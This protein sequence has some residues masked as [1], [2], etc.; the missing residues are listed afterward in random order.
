MR[1]GESSLQQC[2]TMMRDMAESK[3]LT[4]HIIR[5]EH[6][7]F[8]L[9]VLAFSKN[10][11]PRLPPPS[12]GE[13]SFQPPVNVKNALNQFS[14]GFKKKTS[15]RS[16]EW[17]Y[18]LGIVDLSVCHNGKEINVSVHPISASLL[19]YLQEK[20]KTFHKSTLIFF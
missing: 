15:N 16:L 1:F 2:D 9:D 20:R 18:Q 14:E 19:L 5:D 3:R 10:Y 8:P 7:N 13:N 6:I 4:T 11:W 12:S 17:A